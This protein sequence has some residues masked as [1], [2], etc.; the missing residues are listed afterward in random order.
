[1]TYTLSKLFMTTDQLESRLRPSELPETQA[2][3]GD[4]LLNAIQPGRKQAAHLI[5]FI[6]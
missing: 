4:A 5:Y 3:L 1:M 6:A 2:Y